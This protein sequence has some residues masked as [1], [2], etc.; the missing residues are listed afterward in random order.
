MH[1]PF[2][3]NP[4]TR[5]TSGP[6]PQ[7]RADKHSR[8]QPQVRPGQRAPQGRTGSSP[9]SGNGDEHSPR[10]VHEEAYLKRMLPERPR[11]RGPQCR[12]SRQHPS[13]PLGSYCSTPPGERSRPGRAPS[14]GNRS[15]AV[16]DHE[17]IKVELSCFLSS[18][19]A[20][21]CVPL[22]GLAGNTR[23]CTGPKAGGSL[24]RAA[25]RQSSL[26]R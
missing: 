13:Q 26:S 25:W 11:R 20:L 14:A 9:P 23:G 16:P 18:S 4:G 6:G 5:C 10:T 12:R 19:Q 21:R 17:K 24:W 15:S 2:G 8:E 22:L 1:F 7:G 3:S